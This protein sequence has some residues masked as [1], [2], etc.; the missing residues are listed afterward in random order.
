MVVEKWD[1]TVYSILI[2]FE[3]K[4]IYYLTPEETSSL[5]DFNVYSD[6]PF[7]NKRWGFLF[8]DIFIC[9]FNL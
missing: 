6:S 5:A 4:T 8:Y 7:P 1:K 2:T 3:P 9:K